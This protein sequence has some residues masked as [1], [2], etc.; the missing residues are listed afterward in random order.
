MSRR[1]EENTSN[2]F[3]ENV[4]FMTEKIGNLNKSMILEVKK[5]T[6]NL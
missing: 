6:E 1:F 5:L 2:E 3:K 4:S